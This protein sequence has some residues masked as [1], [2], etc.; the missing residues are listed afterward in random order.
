MKVIKHSFQIEKEV[1]TKNGKWYHMVIF[2]FLRKDETDGVIITFNDITEVKN[3]RDT[4]KDILLKIINSK[5]EERKRIAESLHN[6]LAQILYASR[7]HIE[8]LDCSKEKEDID[9]IKKTVLTLL[10]ES[11]NETRTLS[12]QLAPY[13]LQ[14]YGLKSAIEELISR[15]NKT[16]LH[17]IYKELGLENRLNQQLEFAVF[18]IIQELIN[19][20]IK[21][22]DSTE[23]EIN[24]I[25]DRS[26]L[27]L[28][29]WDN[30]KGFDLSKSIDGMGL[31]SIKNWVNL[32][33]GTLSIEPNI[34][35]GSVI[36][37][38]MKADT[39]I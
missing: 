12:F 26:V 17:I 14:D 19:N 2:P 22:S 25:K 13:M 4:Q 27:N 16:N 29:I 6:G 8:R 11:I 28:T 38:G 5:E 35:K 10:E 37:I 18:R 7:L 30:G 36:K 9:S 15:L 31:N 34:G 3:A 24:L 23:A 39:I 32:Y 1:Q 33:L 20:I 21:H